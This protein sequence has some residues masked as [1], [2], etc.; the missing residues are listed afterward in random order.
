MNRTFIYF[1]TIV[2]VWFSG[3][4]FEVSA[5]IDEMKLDFS[6]AFTIRDT[7]LDGEPN[8]IDDNPSGP[9]WGL[10]TNSDFNYDE[11]YLEFDL[12]DL[13]TICSAK[14]NFSFSRSTP[15]VSPDQAIQLKIALYEG[16]GEPD[17]SKFGIG[18][19]FGSILISVLQ[20]DNLS[21]DFTNIIKEFIGSEISHLGIRLYEPISINTQSEIPAQLNFLEGFLNVISVT[22]L[23]DTMQ[24]AGAVHGHAYEK[25]HSWYYKSHSSTL[26][27]K[28]VVK[29][30]GYVIDE[31]SMARDGEGIGVSRAFLRI[32]GREI[33]LRDKKIDLLK[34]DG[35]Y[36]IKEVFK[37]NK[38]EHFQVE[39]YAADTVS[40]EDG[41]PNFG[42]VDSARLPVKYSW[43]VQKK[44]FSH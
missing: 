36:R 42:L 30:D 10:I 22:E 12:R 6:T 41:G 7:D 24:P 16:D 11:F 25:T 5:Q 28:I 29:I 14:F 44:K 33:I 4:D 43:K 34:M 3:S 26:K 20:G 15:P 37:G 40:E 21:V 38:Y 2:L 39:L 17:I 27:K 31:L 18:E 19:F 13:E 1:L 32:N 9:I 23:V 35:S 8:Q